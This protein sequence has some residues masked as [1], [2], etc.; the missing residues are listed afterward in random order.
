MRIGVM[1][2]GFSYGNLGVRALGYS[3]ISIIKEICEKE[4]LND[5]EYLIFSKESTEVQEKVKTELG[6]K[7]MTFIDSMRFKS[8]IVGYMNFIKNIKSCDIIFDV[9]LGDSFSDIYGMKRFI[10][11]C[12]EMMSV[13]ICKTPLVLS[14]QT[15][16]PFKSKLSYY[17]AKKIIKKSRSV[18][19][20]DEASLDYI[21][22]ISDNTNVFLC[23]DLAM[24][25]PYNKLNKNQSNK[26][27]LGINISGLLWNGGYN[28]N[29]Q[30]GLNL[31]YKEFMINLVK[32][33]SEKDYDIYLISHVI[34]KNSVEDDYAACRELHNIVPETYL[35][36]NFTSPIEAK[37]YISQ[38]NLLIGA[39]MHA[40]IAGFSS[41]IPV[42][43]IAY[44][45]K[46]EGLYST[47]KY[48]FNVD[49]NKL[50]IDKAY[51]LVNE[52]IENID[53]LSSKCKIAFE[54]AK[55]KNNGYFNEISKLLKYIYF[56]KN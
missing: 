23:S 21:K 40:T 1:G 36:E 26:V 29:N 49:C 13:Q 35:V 6:I 45:R 9:N 50:S 44:S 20:R 56:Q 10:R 5:I 4:K 41:G 2:V 39:R 53:L 46:F 28:K 12:M 18:W 54:I 3:Q 32:S 42:I 43:P 34:T 47:L 25:L 55:E 27:K 30:F 11:L 22:N 37:T 15:Y 38:L 24:S 19:A 7:N 17:I 48:N 33:L 16:G 14:P 51:E 8:G 52:Y 31:D